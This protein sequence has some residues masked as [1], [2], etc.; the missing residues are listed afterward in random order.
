M[1]SSDL[2]IKTFLIFFINA[3]ATIA[4]PFGINH[5][6]EAS[7][8]HSTGPFATCT[9]NL[10]SYIITLHF[11]TMWHL[12]LDELKVFYSHYPINPH[13]RECWGWHTICYHL[14][15]LEGT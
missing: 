13:P 7:F 3:A 1:C 10:I 11:Y 6:I 2:S 4:G 15:F 5:G 14:S 9:L 12:S 8:Q